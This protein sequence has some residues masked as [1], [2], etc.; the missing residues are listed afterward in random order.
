MK[1]KRIFLMLVVLCALLFAI[2]P[3][4]RDLVPYTLFSVKSG[5]MA[6]AIPTHSIIAVKT[7]D[8]HIFNPY[9][10]ITYYRG[11]RLITHRILSV[12]YEGEIYY[13]TKGDA[14]SIPDTYHVR[15]QDIYGKVVFVTPPALSA[16]ICTFENPKTVRIILTLLLIFATAAN[17]ST[18]E[19]THKLESEV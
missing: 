4:T 14:N 2:T 3:A 8:K 18:D 19:N 13:Q 17:S 7:K 9:E 10:I 12:G 15:H 1:G 16:F 11:D 6:P 5:S